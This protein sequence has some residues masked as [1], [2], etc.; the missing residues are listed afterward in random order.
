MFNSS[1]TFISVYPL[2]SVQNPP[3]LFKISF[4]SSLIC[5]NCAVDVEKKAIT[6]T[7]AGLHYTN[8]LLV[9]GLIDLGALFYVI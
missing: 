2:N 1:H 5:I 8:L 3:N 4:V 9:D 7:V 6:G